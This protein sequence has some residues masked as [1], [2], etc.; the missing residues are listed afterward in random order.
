MIDLSFMFRFIVKHVYV[1]LYV[2]EGKEEKGSTKG[3]GFPAWFD[4]FKSFYFPL[5]GST[6][7]NLGLPFISLIL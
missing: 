1:S 5:F 3:C 6:F 2:T 4:Q 7:Q